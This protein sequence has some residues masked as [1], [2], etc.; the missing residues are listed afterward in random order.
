MS[1]YQ[2]LS[3]TQELEDALQKSWECPVLILKHSTMCP[4]SARAF[5]A[6]TEFT[7]D[8]EGES[9]SCYLVQVIEDRTLSRMIA[10]KMKVE[11]HSPQAILIKDGKPI[12]VTTHRGITGESLREACQDRSE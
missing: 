11:H 8:L 1:G 5:A 3:S 10:D 6:Y 9:L 7:K 4:I 12:W 2:I